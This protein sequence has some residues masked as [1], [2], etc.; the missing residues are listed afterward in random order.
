MV[1][2][3]GAGKYYSSSNGRSNS[4]SNGRSNS[5]SSRNLKALDGIS[6][7]IKKGEIVSFIGPSGSGKTT[8]L[9]IL[10][11]IEELSEGSIEY[12]SSVSREHPAVMV[13]QDYLLFPHM[14]I[15]EN[16]AFG[17]KSR[18][19]EKSLIREKVFTYLEYFGI[20]DKADSYPKQLSAGQQQRAAIAR[21]M[22]IEP[23]LLLL[24]EPFA[25]LDKNLK[26]ETAGFIRGIQ[27]NSAPLL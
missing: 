10:A 17:L 4:S 3:R 12:H 22:V 23:A 27:K 20:P 26:V 21:A 6:L 8:L 19:F 16:T 18:G 24:D 11:G 2:L 5:S 1:T 25:N 14:S 9:K 7:E 13:F 15:F